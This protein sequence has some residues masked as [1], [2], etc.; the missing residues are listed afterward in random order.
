MVLGFLVY[1]GFYFFGDDAADA[2]KNVRLIQIYHLATSHPMDDSEL[3]SRVKKLASLYKLQ[4]NEG[5]Y[6]ALRE[7][8]YVSDILIA[9]KAHSPGVKIVTYEF[10]VDKSSRVE[11]DFLIADRTFI[12]KSKNPFETTSARFITIN[13]LRIYV[14]G[15][16]IRG[17]GIQSLGGHGR[18][19]PIDD[20]MMLETVVGFYGI[21]HDAA[22]KNVRILISAAPPSSKKFIKKINDEI[23]SHPKREGLSACFQYNS[24]YIDDLKKEVAEIDQKPVEL[25]DYESI[26]QSC[27]RFVENSELPWTPPEKNF[28][29]DIDGILHVSGKYIAIFQ[30]DQETEFPGGHFI[31]KNDPQAAKLLGLCQDA[32]LCVLKDVGVTTDTRVAVLRDVAREFEKLSNYGISWA[33]IKNIP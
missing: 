26:Y 12:P 16:L 15:D 25:T 9:E 28:V 33:Q 1:C 13:D 7:N 30:K 6:D 20:K 17:K 8:P 5:L 2:A 24:K 27:M 3:K 4:E 23:A 29:T 22:M 11:M 14:D 18:D 32:T 31:A 10:G 19:L 21:D